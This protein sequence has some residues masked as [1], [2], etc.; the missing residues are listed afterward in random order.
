MGDYLTVFK[1]KELEVLFTNINELDCSLFLA[2]HV[3]KD[4]LKVYDTKKGGCW[5]YR[6]DIKLWRDSCVKSLRTDISRLL[7]KMVEKL[8]II[9]NEKLKKYYIQTNQK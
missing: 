3:Y 9:N 6:E 2:T 7:Q 5:V 8:S 1:I 4:T